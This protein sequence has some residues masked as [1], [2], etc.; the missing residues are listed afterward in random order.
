MVSFRIMVDKTGLKTSVENNHQSE[1]IPDT[2]KDENQTT[3]GLDEVYATM[4]EFDGVPFHTLG[5]PENHLN[6]VKNLQLEHDDV[7]VCGYV[8]S[9]KHFELMGLFE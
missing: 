6:R 1:G 9:G 8:K 4:Y 7:M 2:S 3:Q 5:S